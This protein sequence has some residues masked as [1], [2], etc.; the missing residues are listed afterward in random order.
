MLMEMTVKNVFPGACLVCHASIGENPRPE[1]RPNMLVMRY[2]FGNN[3]G[4]R[5]HLRVS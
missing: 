1:T 5:R 4:I 2:A 3:A